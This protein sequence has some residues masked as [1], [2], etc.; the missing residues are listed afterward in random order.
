MSAEASGVIETWCGESSLVILGM[1][2]ESWRS[3]QKTR[4]AAGQR[5]DV[6]LE[7]AL[8][9]VEDAAGRRLTKALRQHPVWPWLSQ[10]PGLGG[11]HVAML[12]SII[13]DP[14]RFPGQKCSEGHTMPPDFEV[15]D[16]CP[17]IFDQDTGEKCPGV[18]L[19]PRA[20]TGTRALWHYLGLMPG[21]RRRKGVRSTWN[22]KG[23]TECLMPGGLAEHI[24]RQRVPKYRDIYDQTKARLARERGADHL[25][26]IES[27]T[28]SALP[29]APDRGSDADERCSFGGTTDGP[30]VEG[31]A[32]IETR[33][34]LRPIPKGFN[35]HI[36]AIAR[37]VAVKAFVG[38]LL[39]ALKGQADNG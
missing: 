21:T 5:G 32:E 33:L 4:I 38:D 14:R 29:C 24:V 27:Q 2:A 8:R 34:G 19:A 3:L 26:V 12:I 36:D 20:T 1:L 28:G 11:V 15:G 35:A 37:T 7:E 18:M 30:E 17:V 23:K 31:G 9:P 25:S 39:T 10:Y 22:T 6:L 16:P 13:G